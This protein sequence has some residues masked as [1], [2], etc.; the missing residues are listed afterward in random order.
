M[1][2]LLFLGV[3]GIIAIAAAFKI[4]G[5]LFGALLALAA[6][7][8]FRVLPIVLLGWLV[9]KGWRYLKTASVG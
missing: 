1:G 2:R 7:M 6:F 8:L 5:V 9:M 4:F 3:G